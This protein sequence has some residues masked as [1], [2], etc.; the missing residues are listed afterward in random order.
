MAQM[1]YTVIFAYTGGVDALIKDVNRYVRDGWVPVGGPKY[2]EKFDC[3]C[4]A[5]TRTWK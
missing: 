3:W 5:M 1:E 2:M 4:Q